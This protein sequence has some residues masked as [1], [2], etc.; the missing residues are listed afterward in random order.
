MKK[1]DPVERKREKDR[2][3]YEPLSHEEILKQ[4]EEDNKKWLEREKKKIAFANKH[5]A[6]LILLACA[7][8]LP[9][10]VFAFVT[11]IWI[12]WFDILSLFATVAL[13]QYESLGE[14]IADKQ[15]SPE[16]KGFNLFH[17][18]FLATISCYVTHLIFCVFTFIQ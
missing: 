8:S 2:K 5:K 9:I 4:I 15:L 18:S 1:R 3:K 10:C 16:K 17:F 13:F 7:I 6:K 11:N 14:W 12:K